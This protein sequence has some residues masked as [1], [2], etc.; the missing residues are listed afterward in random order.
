[1]E[2]MTKAT[3]EEML[4]IELIIGKILR[5]GVFVSAAV[6]II[7]VLILLITGDSGYPADEFPRQLTQ[8][9]QGVIAFR[10]Y[11]WLMLGLFL[12]IL[13]PVLRVV[14]SIYAFYK[15]K[16]H[17]YVYITIFVLLILLFAMFVGHTGG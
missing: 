16:D 9:F 8:I 2:K 14:I 3:K 5:V 13:T 1:M 12:L 17:L 7:G 11:A 6:M 15:E 10:A 4:K